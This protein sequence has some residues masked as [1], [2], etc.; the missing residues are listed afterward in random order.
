MRSPL[1]LATLALG[2]HAAAPAPSWPVT[3]G[4]TTAPDGVSLAWDARGEGTTGLVFVHGWCCDRRFWREQLDAFGADWRVVSLDLA[5]HGDSGVARADWDVVGLAGDVE[6]VADAAGLERMVL[7]GHSMGGPVCLAAA[8]RMPGR[9][10]AVI[11]V[12]TL[13]DADFELPAELLDGLVQDFRRDF[14]KTMEEAIRSM[15]PAGT[16]PRLVDWVVGRALR[17]D[18]SAALAL[19]TSFKRV[20]LRTLLADAKVPVRCLNAAP[21]PP[22]G[23]PTAI[24]TNRRYAD[25][26]AVLLKGVGHYPMLEKPREFDRR[27]REVLE[28]LPQPAAAP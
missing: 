18:R 3:T 4:T 1:L 28:D 24:Q 9:V 25:Y 11:G 19:M 27:L 21:G 23:R 14:P 6:A 2:C 12:E 8:A 17:T 15:F 5:G 22:A 16:D 26:D 20:D 13:H 7:V 10:L